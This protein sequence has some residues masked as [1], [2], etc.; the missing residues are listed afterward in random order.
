MNYM[1]EVPF[2]VVEEFE[3]QDLTDVKAERNILPV[4][5]G[6]KVR[7]NKATT[8]MNKAKDI[9]SLKLELRI[10]DGIEQTNPQTGETKMAYINKPLFTGIMDLVYG[11][12]DAATRDKAGKSWWKNSQHLVG[13]T[14]FCKALDI[15]A[16]GIKINDEFL[17]NLIGKE[18]LVDV[19]HEAETAPDSDGNK[20]ATGEFR[21]KLKNWKKVA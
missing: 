16:K 17:S 18:V 7:V 8:Q 15:P 10:V 2:D 21:E 13:F 5:K 19:T 9:Y 20:V 12:K 3:V 4:T 14:E 6:L 1:D 11:A